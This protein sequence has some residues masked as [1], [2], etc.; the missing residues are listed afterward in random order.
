V[1]QIKMM[2]LQ[3]MDLTKV[4]IDVGCSYPTMDVYVQADRAPSA[5]HFV[6]ICQGTICRLYVVW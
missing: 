6:P 2:P 3:L 4:S 5:E 1:L